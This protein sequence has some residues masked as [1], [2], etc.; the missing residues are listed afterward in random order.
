[1]SDHRIHRALSAINAA[2]AQAEAEDGVIVTDIERELP[3][4]FADFDTAMRSVIRKVQAAEAMEAAVGIQ[5]DALKIRAQRF[6]NRG[7]R[8]RT[9]L[10]AAMEA[11]GEK[12]YEAPEATLGVRA[13]SVK[14]IITN[15]ALI[16]DRLML[17]TKAP[18]KAE[19]L[20]ELK[21]GKIVIGAELS[22][23]PPSL[24]LRSK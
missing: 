1:M 9:V 8:L 7:A 13:G 16:P 17:I 19:I 14:A 11:V 12:K 4:Q 23:S 5:I 24:S 6:S 18:D 2:M 3:E 21:A 22:N 10:L 20:A 15:E